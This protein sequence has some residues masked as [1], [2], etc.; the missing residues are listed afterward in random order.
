MKGSDVSYANTKIGLI[1]IAS[2]AF[3]SGCAHKP[4]AP[5]NLAADTLKAPSTHIGV[6]MTALPKIDTAFPGADCLLCYATAAAMNSSL[7]T[8]THTLGYEDL[9]DLKKD[10]AAAIRKSGADAVVIDGDI[11]VEDLPSFSATA[12]NIAQ[13]DYSGLAQK[14]KVDK[15]IVI[16][17]NTIGFVRTYAS[18]VPTA[19]PKGAVKGMGYMVNLKNNTYEWYQAVDISK[20]SEGAWDEPPKFPG[21]TNA[22]YQALELAKDILIKP[23]AN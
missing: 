11:N 16:S 12:P 5:V 18:Y 23:F 19:E 14:Y 7:T 17:F 22:Y 1:A 10:I 21:L 13:K 2:L 6:A 4:Q 3:L 8:Y 9:K 20:A 15:L